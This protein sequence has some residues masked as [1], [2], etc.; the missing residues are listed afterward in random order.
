MS[1]KIKP[2]H[3]S[4]KAMLY[5]RQ[6][7]PHQVLRNEESTRLQY[8]MRKRLLDFGWRQIEV[9]DDDL[10]KS[11]AESDRRPGF[12]RMVA[13]VCMGNVG[14]V[15]ARELSRFARNSKDW[16]QLIEVC[17]V[18]DTVLIDHETVYDPRLGNDRLLLGLKG[19][20]N[21]YE[22]DILRLRS[23]EARREKA[24]R[25]ELIVT[26]PVGYVKTA[27]CRL[28]MDADT[29][30]QEAIRLIFRKTLELGAARQVLLWMIE[31]SID[32][33][34]RH[35]GPLG[36][37]VVWRRPTYHNIISILENPAYAGIYAYGK[38]EAV[39]ALEGGVARKKMRRKPKEQWLALLPDRHEAY[40]ARAD[41]ERV[42]EMMVK[43]SQSFRSTAPGAAK[44][45]SALLTGIMRCARCGK[46]LSVR[47]SGTKRTVPRYHCDRGM[48]DNGEP[49]CISVGAL[50]VDDAISAE[51]L[52]VVAPA[53]VEAAL[54]AGRE[55]HAKQDDAVRA[56]ELELEAARYGA[57][58]AW[59]QY[60]VSDPENRHVAG[61]LERRWNSAL[62]RVREI[63]LRIDREHQQ[64]AET[65]PP[66]PEVLAD[67]AR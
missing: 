6:S 15:A 26:A 59:K 11:A 66:A 64:L 56:L 23:V 17:R 55:A 18:V 28:E 60:D 29:R 47:Y 54:S 38:S 20:L 48:L 34:V 40:I 43:N 30:V 33:P 1:D 42:Q 49:K 25:G 46:K 4:R 10:G 2:H 12:E 24:R 35:Y 16:Q 13:D 58:K 37:E 32:V 21:E 44:K 62:E 41:F 50:D 8:G 14:A 51:V 22:L 19:T 65:R 52:R 45:G 9:I 61:E 63:E 3:R 36:S 27:D 39:V 53:A 5:V 7:S 57:Q 67:L 31:H